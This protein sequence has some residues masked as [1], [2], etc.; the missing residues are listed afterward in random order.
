MWSID[1]SVSFLKSWDSALKAAVYFPL[2]HL[3]AH[4]GPVRCLAWCSRDTN[5]L[6]SGENNV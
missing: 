4:S 2:I 6:F 3:L 5:F 1:K